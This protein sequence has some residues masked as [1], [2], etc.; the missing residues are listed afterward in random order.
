MQRRLTNLALAAAAICAFDSFSLV[1]VAVSGDMKPAISRL[2]SKASSLDG[3][4]FVGEFG[5]YRSGV[6]T[7]DSFVFRNGTFMSM[8][9]AK[10]GYPKGVYKTTTKEGVTK[11]IA[12]TPC[13]RTD[14]RIVW[15]G[16]IKGNQIVGV[17]TWTQKRWYRTIKK[18]FWFK[19]SLKQAGRS[20][21]AN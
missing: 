7:A 5:S 6:L 12:E 8:Q 9:C 2:S 15:Q 13:P 21:L 20:D 4:T 19:G 1:S 17:A 11:F 14:A 10:C 18:K 16:T 3:K